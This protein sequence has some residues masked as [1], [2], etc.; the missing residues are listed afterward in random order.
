MVICCFGMEF[1]QRLEERLKGELPGRL[2][3]MEM[4]V[5][6]MN[7]DHFVQ[8]E[9][10]RNAGVLSLFFPSGGEW[11]MALIRRAFHEKDHHS[12][13]ISFPGG[14]F[15]ARD[16]TFEQTALREAEEEI[17][18]NQSKVKVLGALTNLY[19]PVSNFNVFP[20]VAYT[21]ERPDFLPQEGEVEAV[22]EIPLSTLLN[23]ANKFNTT[24]NVRGQQLTNVP[25][26]QFGADTVWGATAMMLNELVTLVK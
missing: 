8:R 7:G 1:I 26:F 10:A 18:V 4:S 9:N 16:V 19:I 17:N 3:Q 13:Q 15:E 23:T 24:I 14:S 6:P 20:Y 5:I 12:R 21:E 2:A 22:L 25:V 11:N